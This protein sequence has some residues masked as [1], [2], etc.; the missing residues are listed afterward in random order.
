MLPGVSL[1][2]LHELKTQLL[3]QLDPGPNI[4]TLIKQY[5]FPILVY[6]KSVYWLE[7]LRYQSVPNTSLF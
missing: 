2:E 6:L 7:L 5:Q 3:S 1:N 4:I